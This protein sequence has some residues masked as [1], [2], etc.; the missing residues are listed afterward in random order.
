MEARHPSYE[1]IPPLPVDCFALCAEDDLAELL[2]LRP[3]ANEAKVPVDG[4]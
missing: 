3:F 2:K 1:R 4:W